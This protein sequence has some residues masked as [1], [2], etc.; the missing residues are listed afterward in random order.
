MV[1]V[2]KVISIHYFGIGLS[3]NKLVVSN[4]RTHSVSMFVVLVSLTSTMT[5]TAAHFI[6]GYYS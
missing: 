6:V 2:Y 1:Y 5:Y 4:T 3:G